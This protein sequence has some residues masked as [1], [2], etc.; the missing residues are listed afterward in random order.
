MASRSS[1]S[2]RF[3]ALWADMAWAKKI[4]TWAPSPEREI[5][6][7]AHAMARTRLCVCGGIRLPSSV[8]EV[9]HQQPA[10]VVVQHR[11]EAGVEALRASAASHQMSFDDL[12]GQ[13]EEIG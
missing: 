2:P 6:V 3:R 4:Q 11:V 1:A 7:R 13:R 8:V 5:S 9:A 12:I 10:G